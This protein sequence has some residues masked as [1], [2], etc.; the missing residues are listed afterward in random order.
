MCDGGRPDGCGPGR[1]VGTAGLDGFGFL[2]VLLRAARIKDNLDPLAPTHEAPELIVGGHDEALGDRHW[3]RLGL[4]AGDEVIVRLLGPGSSDS[5]A[6]V[7][8]PVGPDDL[9][10]ER[11]GR[12]RRCTGP[13][14]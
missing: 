11:P 14:R 5:P 3:A 2:N 13:P 4:V 12:T 8:S 6:E 1:V 7:Y 9:P 10:F